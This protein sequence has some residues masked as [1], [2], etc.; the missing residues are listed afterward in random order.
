MTLPLRKLF[1]IPFV[2]VIVN[3]LLL[4]AAIAANIYFQVF[5]I[6]SMWASVLIAICFVNTVFLPIIRTR[7]WLRF[8]TAFING[9]SFM[10][11]IYCLLF[12][13]EFNLFGV[14]FAFYFGIGLLVY[15]PHFFAFQT[16][17]FAFAK[18]ADIWS[19]AYFLSGVLACI[20]FAIGAKISYSK[21]VNSVQEFKQTGYHHLEKNFMTE[22]I[23]GMHFI[24]H[25]RTTI[26]DGWR[27]PIHEPILILGMWLNGGIDPLQVS[28]ETRLKLYKQEFPGR[29]VK[30]DCSCAI[31]ERSTY[32]KDPLW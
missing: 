4:S 3:T 25:T 14:V 16:C 28:L 13:G 9:V 17:L 7:S 8:I 32:H 6:P 5:C 15:V 2:Q 1:A 10:L 31:E 26:Y 18:P 23:L 24:Y 20:F 12:L 30:H 22:K 21:A 11:S 27:P 29:P 19:R